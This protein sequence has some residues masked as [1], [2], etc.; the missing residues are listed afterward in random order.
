MGKSTISMASFHCYVSS[1]EGT[2]VQFPQLELLWCFLFAG[3]HPWLLLKS[4]AHLAAVGSLR[5]GS[6]W[7]VIAT[8][9]VAKHPNVFHQKNQETEG[10][11]SYLLLFMILVEIVKFRSSGMCLRHVELPG[12]RE[13]TKRFNTPWIKQHNT[14]SFVVSIE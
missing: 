13:E 8:I 11:F 1:P 6:L 7:S 4:G 9:G 10:K 5:V 2:I 14:R 12:T 3:H